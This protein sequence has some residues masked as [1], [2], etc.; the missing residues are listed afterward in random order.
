MF[1]DVVELV[2]ACAHCVLANSVV[3]DTSAM[4]YSYVNDNEI[5]SCQDYLSCD[6]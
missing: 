2:K 6:I 1:R 5:S 4:L 3:K